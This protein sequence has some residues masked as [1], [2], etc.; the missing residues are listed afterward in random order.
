MAIVEKDKSHKKYELSPDFI[1]D[2][3]WCNILTQKWVNKKNANMKL[4]EFFTKKTL[5]NNDRW[6]KPIYSR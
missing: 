3:N 6:G 4:E 5:F 1:E 2:K